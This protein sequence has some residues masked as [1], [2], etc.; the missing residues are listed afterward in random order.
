MGK[1]TNLKYPLKFTSTD[2]IAYTGELPDCF[3]SATSSCNPMDRSLTKLFQLLLEKYCEP[4]AN[5]LDVD[6][7]EFDIECLIEANDD[8]EIGEDLTLQ[9]LLTYFKEHLCYI[10]TRLCAIC[11]DEC[12]TDNT[13]IIEKPI[14]CNGT[15]RFVLNFPSEIIYLSPEET[16]VGLTIILP[17]GVDGVNKVYTIDPLTSTED[18]IEDI[19]SNWDNSIF[20]P[21]RNGNSLELSFSSNIGDSPLFTWVVSYTNSAIMTSTGNLNEITF[22][23]FFGIA[24]GGASNNVVRAGNF[25]WEACTEELSG[26]VCEFLQDHEDRIT[27]L[28]GQFPLVGRGIAVFVQDEEPTQEDFDELYGEVSGFG[29]QGISGSNQIKPGDLWLALCSGDLIEPI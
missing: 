4:S 9:D 28:E 11:C 26:S 23:A 12:G 2:F 25:R 1:L 15:R 21:S 17:G 13:C 29:I 22:F 5:P 6:I 14:A 7:S 19:I 10:Y 18:L 8:I 16:P 27:T 20:T 3:P 24:S